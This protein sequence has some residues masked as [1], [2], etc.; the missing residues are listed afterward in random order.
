MET[1]CLYVYHY[2]KGSMSGLTFLV[3]NADLIKEPMITVSGGGKDSWG[4][5]STLEAIVP[6]IFIRFSNYS[7]IKPV[8]FCTVPIEPALCFHYQADNDSYCSYGKMNDKLLPADQYNLFVQ[9]KTQVH[10]KLLPGDHSHLD[11]YFSKS[12]TTQLALEH[13]FL[14]SSLALLEK[15]KQGDFSAHSGRA[16]GKNEAAITSLWKYVQQK[17]PKTPLITEKVKKLLES[18][19]DK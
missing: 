2:V 6:G 11:I 14:V 15:N 10:Y 3:R 12:F 18:I 19:A 13:P 17:K 7:I 4:T 1:T 9:S 16:D 5:K 8:T